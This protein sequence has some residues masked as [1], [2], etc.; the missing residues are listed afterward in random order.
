M[1]LKYLSNL[2]GELK[3]P[4]INC[5]VSLN[6][7][8]SK[9]CLLTSKATR[10]RIAGQGDQPL[11]NAINNPK[12]AVFD[13]AD[14]KLYVPIVTLSVE[15][16]NKLYEQF[17]IGFL[18][19]VK[20]NKYRSQITNQTANNN[21]NYLIDPTISKIN[22]SF[23]LAFVNEEDRSSFSKYYTPTIGIEDSNT[24]IDQKPFFEIP[25]KNKEE[26]YQATIELIRN[27]HCT[28]GNSLD[29]EY[30]S[31]HYK[32]I[33]IDLSKQTE[34]ENSDVKQQINFIG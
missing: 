33:A 27:A 17:K 7:K 22:R 26:T 29:Y 32:L 16:E 11:F 31:T 24:L 25:V 23:F 5:E 10:N 28:R 18:V 15:N 6:L 9:N 14:C 21:L 12:N 19:T 8:W 30:F 3:I 1:H 34:L 13:V 20:W 4:L 2:L